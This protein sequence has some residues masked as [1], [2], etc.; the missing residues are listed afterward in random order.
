MVAVGDLVNWNEK[1]G[2]CGLRLI[3][4]KFLKVGLPILALSSVSFFGAKFYVVLSC[5]NN[6]GFVSELQRRPII[7]FRI[8]TVYTS[9]LRS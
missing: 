7:L 4:G 1:F 5:D 8:C 2:A 9:L 3:F 6:D